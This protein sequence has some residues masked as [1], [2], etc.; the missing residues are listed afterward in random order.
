MSKCIECDWKKN[1]IV[2]V[3]PDGQVWPCC[4]L[5]N[6]TYMY[7][8]KDENDEWDKDNNKKNKHI[9]KEYMETKDDYNIQKKPLKQILQTKWFKETL[10]NSWKNYDD[11]LYKCKQYCTVEKDE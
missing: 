5:G 11:A 6:V 1:G 9:L 2:T 10:P 7:D 8:I 3:N 4:Y